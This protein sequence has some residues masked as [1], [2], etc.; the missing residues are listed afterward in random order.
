MA[1]CPVL[2]MNC[3]EA[4]TIGL[5]LSGTR[6]AVRPK[7]FLGSLSLSV[8]EK[9]KGS[10]RAISTGWAAI[11]RC[12]WPYSPLAHGDTHQQ[13][14]RIL[15]EVLVNDRSDL[16]SLIDLA[17]PFQSYYF[18]VGCISLGASLP[19]HKKSVGNRATGHS[20]PPFNL[21]CHLPFKPHQ[22]CD[23]IP[24]FLQTA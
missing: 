24:T 8:V 12:D 22:I 23:M 20:N 18:L 11:S 17:S 2:I 1:V 16:S 10:G 19:A 5:V 9:Q 4:V 15:F 3:D 7:L 21:H 14:S 6:T 13:E